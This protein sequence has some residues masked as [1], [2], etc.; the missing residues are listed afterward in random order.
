MH[1]VRVY[2]IGVRVLRGPI[3]TGWPKKNV[4]PTIN[5]FKRTSDRM[6]KLCALLCVN[7]FFQQDDTKI[8]NFDESVLILYGRF[9]KAMSF[10]NLPLLSQKLP[11][12]TE[13]FP[14]FGFPA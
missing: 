3:Y 10:Q 2:I 13:N 11:L 5:D 6:K 4:T 9:S 8:I 1:L 14:L 7:V 12:T